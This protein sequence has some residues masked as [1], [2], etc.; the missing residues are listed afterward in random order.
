LSSEKILRLIVL[1]SNLNSN[2]QILVTETHILKMSNLI[3]ICDA[4]RQQSHVA[5]S[6]VLGLERASA[7]L[8]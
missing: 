2:L 3:Q 5:T 1:R 8:H 4:L 6:H 7:S